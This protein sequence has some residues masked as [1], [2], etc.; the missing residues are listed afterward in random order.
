MIGFLLKKTFFDGWDS[1][2]RLVLL[3]LGFIASAAVP[4]FGAHLL[5]ANPPLSFAVFI[6]GVL[7]CFVYLTASALVL[8]KIS[9]YG[10]FGFGDLVEALKDSWF[11]GLVLGA[12]VSGG[13][14][15]GSIVLPFYFTMGSMFGIFAAALVFWTLVVVSLALQYYLPLRA[16]LDR[17]PRKIVKKCFI[18]FFDNPG[19]SLFAAVHNL[20]AGVLS[21]F[22]AMMIPGP[23][24]I[25]LFLDEAL[26]LRLLKYD[27]L[28]AHPDADRKKIPWDDLLAE[29]R[30]KTGTRSFRSFIFPWKD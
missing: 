15:L 8:R 1:L 20:V 30:E 21:L 12:M 29:D 19:F 11:S 18:L 2:F 7:W 9:D 25:L 16:R 5:A 6:L 3:N 27:Y 4:I 13:I 24:A 28:E 14:F 26:R 10:M 23:A 22:L 17:D